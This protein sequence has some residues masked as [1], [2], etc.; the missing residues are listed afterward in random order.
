VRRPALRLL[1]LLCAL[2]LPLQAGAGLVSGCA[3]LQD[4]AGLGGETGSTP[5]DMTGHGCC[6]SQGAETQSQH[7]C[8]DGTGDGCQCPKVSASTLPTPYGAASDP[9]LAMRP[10][11]AV[12]ALI[13]GTRQDLL[14]PPSL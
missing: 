10:S 12:P 7:G 2:L 3:D 8:C 11:V 9:P 13:A 14:R 4:A 6:P 5:A 1:V